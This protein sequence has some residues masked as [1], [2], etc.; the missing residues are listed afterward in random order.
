MGQFREEPK[1]ENR[2]GSI[3]FEEEK[4]WENRGGKGINCQ[5]VCGQC[6][7]V[8]VCIYLYRC[9]CIHV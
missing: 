1:V 4:T 2:E 8:Y 6:W 7:S 3:L 5:V 9:L